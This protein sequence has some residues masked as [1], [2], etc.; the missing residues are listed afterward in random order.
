MTVIIQ[1]IQPVLLNG[2]D[3]AIIIKSLE[4]RIKLLERDNRQMTRR[5]Q[6]GKCHNEEKTNHFMSRIERQIE[7]I[8]NIINLLNK[9]EVP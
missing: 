3:K 2:F 4:Q 8:N 5:L 6:E 7:D 1:K 9:S